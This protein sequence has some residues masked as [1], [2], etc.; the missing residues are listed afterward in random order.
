M[1]YI[2]QKTIQKAVKTS[3][4]GLHS[5][6]TVTLKLVPAEANTGIVFKRTDVKESEAIVF[7]DFRAVSA[8]M[9][10]TT[11]ENKFGVEV[12]TVEHLLAA[13]WGMEIDNLLI[14]ID[15]PEVPIMDGSS[16]PFIELVAKAGVK[17]LTTPRKI[18]RILDE[19]R[20]GDK[21]TYAKL[22][23]ANGFAVR[24]EIDFSDKAIA[25]QKNE[26][27][28]APNTFLED[29]ARARTFCMKKDVDMMH[30]AGL[31]RGGSLDNAI[32][33]DN[34][35]VLNKEGLRFTDEFVRHKILDSIG[36]LYLAGHRIE[37]MFIGHRSGHK[38]NNEALRTLIDTPKAW[39]LVD[40]TLPQIGETAAKKA[41]Y[42]FA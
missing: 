25:H 22:A 26:F 27:Q 20:V 32:V 4:I 5:G 23:P 10:G 24:F 13:L 39:E 18:I 29:I 28:F 33:V 14:E 15:S 31:A 8:T 40:E 3:G 41:P 7:A 6:K 21:Q 38:T 30:S 42:S 16:A 37:G 36:D 34:G 19:I 35:K 12:A 11:L 17:T 9:L 1:N 2:Y